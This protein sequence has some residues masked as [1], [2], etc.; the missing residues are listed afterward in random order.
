MRKETISQRFLQSGFPSSQN[1]SGWLSVTL[2]TKQRAGRLP[3]LL[4]SLHPNVRFRWPW[5]ITH[6]QR[7]E[8]EAIGSSLYFLR[9]ILLDMWQVVV[10]LRPAHALLY[11][12]SLHDDHLPVVE[13][14]QLVQRFH[15]PVVV[16]RQELYPQRVNTFFDFLHGVETYIRGKLYSIL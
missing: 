15:I 1:P 13:V 6:K 14:V 16:S 4:D 11:R 3:A 2:E 8:E 5:R 9:A 10:M 12:R 7:G